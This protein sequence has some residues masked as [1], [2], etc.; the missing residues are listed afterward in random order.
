[1]FFIRAMS[2]RMTDRGEMSSCLAAACPPVMT[3]LKATDQIIQQATL[4][5]IHWCLTTRFWWA[6]DVVAH[7]ASDGIASS[8]DSLALS[9]MHQ[10]YI[11][12]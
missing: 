6:V 4:D 5:F 12:R 2:K 3:Q 1:M 11:T 7:F 9:A 10:V 8:K